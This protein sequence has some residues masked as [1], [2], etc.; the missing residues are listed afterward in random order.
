[1]IQV[2]SLLRELILRATAM[3]VEYDEQGRDG[4]IVDLIFEEIEWSSAP[5]LHM[6]APQ[7]TRLVRMQEAFARNPGDKRTLEEWASD[8]GISCRTLARLFHREIGITFRH[9]RHQMRVLAAVPRLAMGEQVTSVALEL[10]Y[11]SPGAFA[12]MFRRLMGVAPSQYFV[13]T[14]EF[15]SKSGPHH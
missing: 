10:G 5:Q 3:P 13:K 7:D 11:D 14:T 9:W 1:M 4:K 2:S 8:E 15:S 6:P 12:A